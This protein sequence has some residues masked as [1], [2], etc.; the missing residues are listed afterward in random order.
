MLLNDMMVDSYYGNN[1]DV[2][3]ASAHVESEYT[4]VV[5]SSSNNNYSTSIKQ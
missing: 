5:D 2:F 4:F 3:V 1:N